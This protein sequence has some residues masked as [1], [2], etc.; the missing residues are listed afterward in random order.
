[1]R[2]LIRLYLQTLNGW[3]S[4]ALPLVR[5]KTG[6]PTVSLLPTSLEAPAFEIRQ[7]DEANSINIEKQDLSLFVD[8][9]VQLENLK[10]IRKVAGF[11]PKI[12]ESNIIFYSNYN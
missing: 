9:I 4:K 6:V 7:E 2:A 5:N 11:K 3:N 10:T 8:T 1:M 12:Q